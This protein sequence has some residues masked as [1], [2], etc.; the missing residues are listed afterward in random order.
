[1]RSHHKKDVGIYPASNSQAELWFLLK[2]IAE[3]GRFLI[4]IVY[5]IDGEINLSCLEG[6]FNLLVKQHEILRTNFFED[7]T[8]K[9]FQI[10]NYQ[11]H[12]KLET[13]KKDSEGYEKF[14]IHA[15]K[16]PCDFLKD[17]LFRVVLLQCLSESY[18][19]I[20]FRHH[21]I[22]DGGSLD[23]I[24]VEISNL[25]KALLLEQPVS[26]AVAPKQYQQFVKREANHLNSKTY[27]KHI[28]SLRNKFNHDKAEIDS[29]SCCGCFP[30]IGQDMELRVV[31]FSAAQYGAL[32]RCSTQLKASKFLILLAIYCIVLLRIK[33]TKKIPVLIPITTRNADDYAKKCLGNFVNGSLFLAQICDDDSFDVIINKCKKELLWLKKRSSVSF[34]QVK[35]LLPQFSVQGTKTWSFIFS[36]SI[37]LRHSL[38]LYG[39]SVAVV[40]YDSNQ[41]LLSDVAVEVAA[42]SE[43]NFKLIFRYC[44]TSYTNDLM[45]YYTDCYRK[46]LQFVL[47]NHVHG[48]YL[49]ILR[50]IF[51]V[52]GFVSMSNKFTQIIRQYP[53]L[54]AIIDEEEKIAYKDLGHRVDCLAAH[55][56]KLGIVR[57]SRV[58]IV[59]D[60]SANFV[61]TM[62]ACLKLGVTYIPIDTSM[63]E[64]YLLFVKNDSS[65]QWCITLSSLLSD[66]CRNNIRCVFLDDDIV[67]ST[68]GFNEAASFVLPS[69]IAYIIYTSGTT[70]KPKGV[71]ISQGGLAQSVSSIIDVY[72]FT[73]EDRVAFVHSVGFDFS[74]WEILSALLVGA[75]LVVCSRNVVTD[76]DKFISYLMKKA[77]TILNQTPSAL[78]NLTHRLNRY[79]KNHTITLNLRLIILGGEALN[80]KLISAW[81]E[82]VSEFGV[83]V[84]IYNMYG[85]TEGTI[86]CSIKQISKQDADSYI[87]NIGVALP[88]INF[89]IVSD[90]YK[91]VSVNKVGELLISG[92]CLAHGY[93]NDFL[94][95]DKKFV[96]LKDSN[97]SV[98]RRWFKTGDLVRVLSNGDFE[99][100]SRNDR[101]IS[102]RGF[103][104]EPAEIERAIMSFPKI[105][106]AYV[107]KQVIDDLDERLIC[108]I[109]AGGCDIDVIFL[110]KHLKLL[111]PYYM[112]PSFI[113]QIT[114]I[115]LTNNGKIDEKKLLGIIVGGSVAEEQKHDKLA[116][117]VFYVTQSWAD[118]LGY[119]DIDKNANF[120]DVGGHSLL[121]NKL[122]IVL[123]KKFSR[124]I[125]IMD[126]FMYSSINK[127][128]KFIYES[129]K[130]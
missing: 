83:N 21:L 81:F 52:N 78:Y 15:Q 49:S 119:A 103:R 95:T 58:L 130:E 94:L 87:S 73:T 89:K 25:Y 90:G 122:C 72:D 50:E 80:P 86:H 42:Y 91:D 99:Y 35:R 104:I 6:A 120:F 65:A 100:I 14:I 67:D 9:L 26:F 124:K 45:D 33:A 97:A 28:E 64:E 121:L 129:Q 27:E 1:M 13:Q 127:F 118:V 55:M 116:A 4:P 108:F 111:L 62:F 20:I 115:P 2:T 32:E 105:E 43:R 23:I 3:P 107:F 16:Q 10:V 37:G 18:Y 53:S 110:R 112:I 31:E 84:R 51:F 29:G 60:R 70:G 117:I 92:S 22:S 44:K 128:A 71:M 39:A 57:G 19:L 56:Y 101:Q 41:V 98:E 113:R 38:E 88:H 126:L 24:N 125:E 109:V 36:Q 68:T 34:S 7:K 93:W 102:L 74:V 40:K 59:L 17:L 66:N 46:V 11:S 123:E 48:F 76:Q 5:R 85:I 77:I 82:P 12:F 8:G 30:S 47:L 106:A 96:I 54:I 63:P 114:K 75:S 61:I 69:D 79:R